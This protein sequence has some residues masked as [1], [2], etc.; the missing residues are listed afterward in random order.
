MRKHLALGSIII[1]LFIT[2][3]GLAHSMEKGEKHE[4]HTHNKE[5]KGHHTTP[6]WA[7][8]LNAEQK[9]TVDDMH[10]ELDRMLEPLKADEK[11]KQ[12][13]LNKLTVMDNTSLS[14]INNK[15]DELMSIKNQIL[16]HRYGHLVEMRAILNDEQRI[17]Y[18]E[19]VMKRDQIK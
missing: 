11:L 2:Y 7:K 4:G 17:S 1:A 16:R 18:D 14:E 12:Q 9:K 19:A 3:N 15:I 5:E 10:H 8:S 6:H 13:E